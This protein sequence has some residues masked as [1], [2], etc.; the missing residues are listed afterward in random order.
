MINLEPIKAR[1]EQA[2]P[3][4]WMRNGK[5]AAGWRI[6]D[7]SD[8]TGVDFLMKPMAVVRTDADAIFIEHSREDIPDLVAEVERLR[9]ELA[10]VARK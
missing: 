9:A 10:S 1:V 2:S 5:A 4:P 6:D 7:G 3:D 8:R